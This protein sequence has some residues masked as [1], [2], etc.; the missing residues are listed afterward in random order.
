MDRWCRSAGCWRSSA[1]DHRLTRGPP[2]LLVATLASI[3]ELLVWSVGRPVSFNE[4]LMSSNRSSVQPLG[5]SASPGA[6]RCRRR[7]CRCRSRAVDFRWR[8]TGTARVGPLMMIIA[9]ASSG[10]S[11]CRRSGCRW[12]SASCRCR[13]CDG[14]SR[15]MRR[16]CGLC[17]A[18]W[19]SR[20]KERTCRSRHDDRLRCGSSGVRHVNLRRC[21]GR[22]LWPCNG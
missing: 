6:R 3:G 16:W 21:R 12:C 13:P 2:G 18:L 4:P 10:A 15:A 17:T 1:P 8:T 9:R 7:D 22:Q 5:P 11:R 19:C 14:R 20:I